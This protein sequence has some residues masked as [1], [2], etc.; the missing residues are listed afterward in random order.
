AEKPILYV[1]QGI[2]ARPEGPKLLKELADKACIPV[3]TTL[4]ALG[5]FDEEDPKAL[6]MLGMHGSAY[7]NLAMQEADLIIAMGARFDDRVTLSIS[8]FA[9]QAKIAAAE[10]RGGIVQFEVM[11]KNIN[12]VVEADVAV[13]GDCAENISKLLPL[14]QSVPERPSW[15]AQ[16]NSWK[17]MFPFSLYGKEKPEGP[18]KPQ[19]VIA[20]LSDLTN[21]M[22][23]RTII[24]TGVG[25]HQMWA[26]QHF[27]WRHPRTMV[28]SGGL[29]TM[30]YGL[31][32][33][34]GAK[35]ARPD[36]LVINIDGDG[37]FNMTLTEMSTAV[38]ANL[39]VKTLLLNNEELGMVTQWQNL[40]YEDRF[41]HTHTLNPNYVK[42]AEAMHTPARRVTRPDEV[43][44]ALKWLIEEKGPAFLEVMVE[45]KEPVLPMVP[46]GKGLHEFL[47]YDEAK[48]QERRKLMFQRSG[49]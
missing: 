43:E 13:E 31:P 10:N 27:R 35:A 25:Q 39:G 38:Q 49:Y 9:P 20:K 26:A 24:T 7:A 48:D 44:D 23:E 47:V 41:A 15:F 40:F 46:A 33:A 19:S 42:L 18:I 16:I 30:G 36:A 5:S 29:G 45:K 32:S 1:G 4:H 3:T 34:I 14:I 2:L 22:K 11:P 17:K 21:H 37:S 28:T 8:K 12:K 6:H